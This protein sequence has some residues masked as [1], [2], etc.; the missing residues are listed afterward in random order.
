MMEIIND[1]VCETFEI[2]K[3]FWLNLV[4]LSGAY[5]SVI[6]ISGHRICYDLANYQCMNAFLKGNAIYN[7]FM[8]IVYIFYENTAH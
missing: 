3:I 8:T 5:F 6:S 7:A 1:R 2:T 4:K